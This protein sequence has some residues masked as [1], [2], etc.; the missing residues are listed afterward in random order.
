MENKTF[1]LG[2]ETW[3]AVYKPQVIIKGKY[4]KAARVPS[5]KEIWL[6]RFDEHWNEIEEST[7]KLTFQKAILP[8]A[9]KLAEDKYGK[10]AVEQ[11]MKQMKE[12]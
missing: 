2:T 10:E 9:M 7:L 6:S 3:T 4:M 8:L 1:Q 5:R 11:A 12:N